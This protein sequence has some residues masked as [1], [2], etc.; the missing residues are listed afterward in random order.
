V[1]DSHF[2][3]TS[4]SVEEPGES[5]DTVILRRPLI[6]AA[7]R[8]SG[9]AKACYAARDGMPSAPEFLS[10]RRM[11]NSIETRPVQAEQFQAFAKAGRG[12]ATVVPE[13]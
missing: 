3:R 2:N 8:Q 9:Q 5:R 13:A 1:A 6:K 11:K 4:L 7:T 10:L 12:Q